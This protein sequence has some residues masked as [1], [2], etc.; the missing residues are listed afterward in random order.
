MARLGEEADEVVR[1]GNRKVHMYVSEIS[2][3]EWAVDYVARPAVIQ[4]ALDAPPPPRRRACTAPT[5][6]DAVRIAKERFRMMF[7]MKKLH[8]VNPNRLKFH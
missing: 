1:I 4:R 3:G 7:H 8:T 6:E 2:E 5:R